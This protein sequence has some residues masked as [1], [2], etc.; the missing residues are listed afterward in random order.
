MFIERTQ[1]LKTNF[2][3]IDCGDFDVQC[4]VRDCNTSN[5][6]R[7]DEN[8]YRMVVDKGSP[9]ERQYWISPCCRDGFRQFSFSS[10]DNPMPARWVCSY[11]ILD[12]LAKRIRSK[13][14]SYM[15]SVKGGR[16]KKLEVRLKKCEE[17]GWQGFIVEFDWHSVIKRHGVYVNF[18]F[19]KNDEHPFDDKVQRYSFSLDDNNRPNRDF[20]R[21]QYQ[22]ISAF[23]DGFL[24]GWTCPIGDKQLKFQQMADLPSDELS[25]KTLVFSGD[26]ENK[27]PYWGVRNIGPYQKCAEMP[28]FFFVFQEKDRS[29]ARFLYNCLSGRQ[30]N[31]R[32]SGMTSFFSVPFSASNIDHV[33]MSGYDA[34]AHE[35]AAREILSKNKSNPVAIILVSGDE[36][37]YLTQKSIY[38]EHNIPSQDVKVSKVV[39][40][41]SF[42]WSV[43]GI[44][45]QLFCK[46]G[47]IPWCV[48]TERKNDLIIGVSQLW[49]TSVPSGNRFVAYSVTTDASGAFKDIRTLSDQT[50]ES[51]YVRTLGERIKQQLLA[52]ISEEHPHRIV[53]HCSF[54]LLKSAME[55]IRRVVREV[56]ANDASAPGIVI[57]RINTEHHYMGFD[58]RRE[59]L[60]PTENAIMRIK[61][62][63]YLV[64]PDGTPSGGV[65]SSRPSNPIYAIFDRMEPPI[66]MREE[67]DLLQDLCNLSGVNWRG[68]NAKARPVSVFYCHLVG[69]MM[70]DMA[71]LGL[72]LPAIEKFVPWFL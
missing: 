42:Q 52:H 35:R 27:N 3:P 38:L 1:S 34:S 70:S 13:N 53:L 26:E 14:P 37:E 50:N 21:V 65:V 5:E 9:A 51:D 8:T 59:T 33:V 32:F 62:R 28:N 18:H 15:V 22:W 19:F 43:A 63:G 4:F 69:R 49:D 68:F 31:G 67:K 24:A 7:P 30:F 46:A 10:Q 48:K 44:A 55:E 54:R 41:N 36:K 23:Y 39:A 25:G 45:L 66:S 61:P 71:A 47:G 2:F 20:Y 40:G 16:F 11:I 12:E 17:V 60:V 64:W 72:K 29:T 6:Q 57:V 56:S 58:S